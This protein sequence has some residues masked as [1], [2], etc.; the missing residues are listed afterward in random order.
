MEEQRTN[1]LLTEYE[2]CLADVSQLDSDIWQSGSMLVG[3]SILLIS[4]LFQRQAQ[5][6]VVFAKVLGTAA[7]GLTVTFIW[8][9]LFSGWLRLIYIN[10]YRMR[11]IEEELDMRRERYIGS[12]DET[13][14]PPSALGEE[15]PHVLRVKRM[16]PSPGLGGP[17]GIHRILHWL[18]CVLVAGWIVLVLEQLVHV[19]SR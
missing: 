12:L 4:L 2:V 18:V 11:E 6:W 1:V 10:F 14:G 13:L 8:H 5:S 19:L 16:L 15:D 3:V 7:F 17:V 9:K